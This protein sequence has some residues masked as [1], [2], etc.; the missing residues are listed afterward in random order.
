[1]NTLFSNW[2]FMRFFRLA[3]A[4]FSGWQAF[5]TGQWIFWLFTAFFLLQSIFN[6][7]CGPK[8]C[9]ISNTKK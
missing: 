3:L 4:V 2:H 1:M 5:E 7:G 6:Y 9:S 8:G